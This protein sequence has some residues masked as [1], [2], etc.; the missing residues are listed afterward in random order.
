MKKLI[1]LLIGLLGFSTSCEDPFELTPTGIISGDIVFADQN[2]SNA[3]LADLYERSLFHYNSGGT[4]IEM[5]LI[6]SFGGEARNFAP[7]QTPFGQVLNTDFNETGAGIID[8]WPYDLIRESN[9]YISGLASSE[10][11]PKAY[12][13]VRTSE[14][15]AT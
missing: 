7:W 12:T 4:N 6:N 14:A 3:F 13:D 9:V 5:N 8:Y 15:R 10:A 2:L 11:L 1:I